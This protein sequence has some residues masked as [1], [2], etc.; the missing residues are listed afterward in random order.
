MFISTGISQLPALLTLVRLYHADVDLCNI[1]GMTPLML[2][3]SFGDCILVN[4]SF[5]MFLFV[6][7]IEAHHTGCGIKTICDVS[8]TAVIIS[9]S[10]SH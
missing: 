3:A 5:T 4:V 8:A 9:C 10:L 1:D 6:L 7:N 2:A